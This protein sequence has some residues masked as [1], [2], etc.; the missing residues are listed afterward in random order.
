MMQPIAESDWKTFRAIREAARERFCDRLLSEVASVISDPGKCAYDRY[1]A[2][3]VIL[4][5]RQRE[6]ADAFD[7]LRRSTALLRLATFCSLA[8][9]TRDEFAR[10]SPETRGEI[11]RFFEMAGQTLTWFRS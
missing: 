4:S 1:H 6:M 8:L 10:F 9:L 5:N 3:Q 7:D 11:E 2:I